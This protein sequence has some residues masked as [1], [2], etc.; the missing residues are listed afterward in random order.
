MSEFDVPYTGSMQTW[1]DGENHAPQ[2]TVAAVGVFDGVH[3]GHQALLRHVVQ[4]AHE[5]GATPAVVTFTPHPLQVVRPDAVVPMLARIDQRLE[6]FGELGIEL[7]RLVTFTPAV[8]IER[9]DEFVHRVLV[10]ELAVREVIVGEDFHLGHGRDVGTGELAALGAQ[11]GFSVQAESLVGDPTKW[12]SRHIREDLR[13]G[14][15]ARVRDAL[16]RYFVL[17]APVESGDRRG[18]EIGYPTANL[19][20]GPDQALPAEGVYA[21]AVRIDSTWHPAALSVGSRPQYYDDGPCLV[22]VHVLDFAGDLYDRTL[23]VAFLAH[24]RGQARFA[25]E[26]DLIAQIGRDVEATRA[27]FADFSPD[28]VELLG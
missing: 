23:D 15:V 3:R 10:G 20:F 19:A 17:R 21:G 27:N 25:S 18:R 14:D 9:G 6:W 13:R 22:E 1:R 11:M 2:P 24:L 4:R 26:T 5:L 12:G 8:A 7:V 16:G 28:Q